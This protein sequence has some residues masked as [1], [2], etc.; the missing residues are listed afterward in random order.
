MSY[1]D[2]FHLFIHLFEI[3]YFMNKERSESCFILNVVANILEN[4]MT[5]TNNI[6]Y[7]SVNTLYSNLLLISIH[8]ISCKYNIL[9]LNLIQILK[10][11]LE[12]KCYSAKY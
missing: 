2:L 8:L 10:Y 7:I 6:R 11:L 1:P 5:E 4:V 12:D 9:V 3:M